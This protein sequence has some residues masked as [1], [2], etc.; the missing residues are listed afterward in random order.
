MIGRSQASII[1]GSSVLLRSAS[2]A[3]ARAQRDSTSESV[4]AAQLCIV[5]PRLLVGKRLIVFSIPA[6]RVTVSTLIET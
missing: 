2:V 6:I 4:V 5:K 3:S 1:T